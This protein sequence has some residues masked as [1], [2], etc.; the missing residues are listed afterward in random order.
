M[1]E[2]CEPQRER[3]QILMQHAILLSGWLA[4]A[5]S[6]RRAQRH[7]T[8]GYYGA[9]GNLCPGWRHVGGGGIHVLQ[10]WQLPTVE[11]SLC[12]GLLTALCARLADFN[13]WQIADC[14]AAASATADLTPL[15]S[16]THNRLLAQ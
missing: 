2:F 12:A 15:T 9:P 4:G 1:T 10:A 8:S 13:A 16:V 3:S 11:L 14:L 6:T 5:G 7:E